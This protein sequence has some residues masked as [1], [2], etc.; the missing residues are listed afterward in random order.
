[1]LEALERG[2]ESLPSASERWRRLLTDPDAGVRLT[3]ERFIYEA[4]HG[5]AKQ[6]AEPE[7]GPISIV[8]DVSRGEY[9]VDVTDETTT[10]PAVETTDE[11][12]TT[13]KAEE[14]GGRW[15]I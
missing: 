14:S 6:W 12:T 3:A 2:G 15:E 5:R 7:R 1:M 11:T 4:V 8:V 10:E 13:G 9:A